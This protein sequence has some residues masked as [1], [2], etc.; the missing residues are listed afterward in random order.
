MACMEDIKHVLKTSVVHPRKP[1]P[2][3]RR[4][5]LLKQRV[6]GAVRI[7]QMSRPYEVK[8]ECLR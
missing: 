8:I 2:E 6:R 4:L 1:N 5:L 3:I 7:R